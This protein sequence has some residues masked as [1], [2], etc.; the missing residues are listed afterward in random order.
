M[1]DTFERKPMTS[2]QRAARNLFRAADAV[3]AMTEHERAQKAFQENR[4]RLK[5]LR[6]AR[7]AKQER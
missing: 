4:E 5:T 6:L 1:S 2:A 3:V 7:D